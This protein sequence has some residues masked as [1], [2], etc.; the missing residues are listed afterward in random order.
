M[1][2]ALYHLL[3]NLGYTTRHHRSNA[4]VRTRKREQWHEFGTDLHLCHHRITKFVKFVVV[5]RSCI[6]K[7]AFRILA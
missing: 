6:S 5:G 2:L 1:T 7:T 4:H 3:P